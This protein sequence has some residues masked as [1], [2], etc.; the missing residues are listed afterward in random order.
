MDLNGDVA[1]VLVVDEYMSTPKALAA[2][3]AI[4]DGR[5]LTLSSGYFTFGPTGAKEPWCLDGL[6]REFR[7]ESC[8]DH[9]NRNTGEYFAFQ[10]AHLAWP[11]VQQDAALTTDV[12]HVPTE[13]MRQV[14]IWRNTTS[15]GFECQGRRE[16]PSA[17]AAGD[18]QVGDIL[19][20]AAPRFREELP[21]QC[22]A[23]AANAH[24]PA[25]STSESS[26]LCAAGF[27]HSFWTN[28]AR[29]CKN[30]AGA[31]MSCPTQQSSTASNSSTSAEASSK[32]V[33]GL[34]SVGG[35]DDDVRAATCTET[36]AGE[37]M[38][39]WRVDLSRTRYVDSVG[40]YSAQNN[41]STPGGAVQAFQ[42][43]VGDSP[44][45]HENPICSPE[46]DSGVENQTASK[47][48]VSGQS[49]GIKCQSA[50]R[51]VFVGRCWR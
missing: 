31:N 10:C 27:A 25:G 4:V 18:W 28:L 33:D 48:G 11:A 50:G 29:S 19:L 13:T 37:T 35:S 16:P 1:G 34:R 24:A 41:W 43:R 15:D 9:S 45:L 39:W 6:C 42:I 36:L 40:V 17:M 7:V 21:L 12:Y 8:L 14:I 22:T 3:D 26:C 38:A 32:A 47:A 5:D 44:R 23:C 46:T 51:W 20:N 2:A 30:A 49:Q